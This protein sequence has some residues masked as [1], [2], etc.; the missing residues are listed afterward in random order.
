MPPCY[1]NVTWWSSCAVQ[2]MRIF[3]H[4]SHWL[5]K[6]LVRTAH[7]FSYLDG[8]KNSRLSNLTDRQNL[9]SI[10]FHQISESMA[11]PKRVWKVKLSLLLCL[12]FKHYL[13]WVRKTKKETA[14]KR[15]FFHAT[16]L[17]LGDVIQAQRNNTF[18]H[19]HICKVIFLSLYMSVKRH[20][21]VDPHATG[22]IFLLFS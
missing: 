3:C 13:E 11:F 10:G 18:L 20:V 21:C 15:F 5:L 4:Q 7:V 14:R 9:Q 2:N 19:T 8:N 12:Y 1:Q 17:V 6:E 22:A 16:G